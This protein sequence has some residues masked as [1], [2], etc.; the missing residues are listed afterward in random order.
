MMKSFLALLVSCLSLAGAF[1]VPT[2][3]GRTSSQLMML[4]P[5]NV[6]VEQ[7]A[8]HLS[9]STTLQSPMQEGIRDYASTF[10]VALQERKPV[11]AE[12][13]AAKKR[14]FNII[15]WVSG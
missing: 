5:V 14:N 13:I 3:H 4:P 9:P 12:E 11:T 6:V 8:Q 10:Q 15:F 7:P 1:H 2:H